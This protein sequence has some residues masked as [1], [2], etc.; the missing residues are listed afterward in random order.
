MQDLCWRMCA[1]TRVVEARRETSRGCAGVASPFVPILQHV[2]A[3]ARNVADALELRVRVPHPA[4]SSPGLTRR[5]R[6]G[7]QGRALLNEMA[8]E[9]GPARLPRQELSAAHRVNPMCGIKP[10]HD[11]LKG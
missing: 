5:S 6:L 3:A 10:G 7:R 2:P 1:E 4:S 8:S 9:V 11:E